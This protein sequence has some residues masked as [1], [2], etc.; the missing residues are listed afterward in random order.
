MSNYELALKIATEAHKGQV[1][2]A[3]VPYINHPLTVAS[4]VD[5]EEEKIVA[6]LHDTIE[7]T[8]I[9]EQDLLNYGFSNKIVEAVKLLTHNK[10]VPY[11]DYVAKIKDNELAR[12]VKIADLT[13]NS[14]LSRLKEI[15]D[16]DKK[17][18]NKYQKALLYLT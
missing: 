17:R 16:K 1:D 6:L 7:D 3:G 8:N 13:H 9:T 15:T 18:Y 14:D 5:T 12:K 4:L 10:N 2:K 11:M